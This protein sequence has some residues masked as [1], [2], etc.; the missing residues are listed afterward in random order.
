MS[1]ILRFNGAVRRSPEVAL[2]L[3]AASS[4]L[5]ELGRR[6]FECMRRSGA[7]V[8]ELLHD[9][10]LTACVKD[11]P[12]AYVGIFKDHVSIGFFHGAGLPDPARLLEGTGKHMR[13]VKVKPGASVNETALQQLITA[14]HRD[15]VLALAASLT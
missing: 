1:G 15:I 11:A 14:A 2:L 3:D 7:D 12:F 9:G 6:W 4:E 8:R 5:G 13:H 10:L